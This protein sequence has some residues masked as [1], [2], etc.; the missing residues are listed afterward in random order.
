[1]QLSTNFAFNHNS[2]IVCVLQ[3]RTAHHNSKIVCASGEGNTNFQEHFICTQKIR[4]AV[5]D[6]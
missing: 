3:V 1:M 4:K 6:F 2:R 5:D